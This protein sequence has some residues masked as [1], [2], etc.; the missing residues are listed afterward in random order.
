MRKVR[1]LW[2]G[3]LW[4]GNN[5]SRAASY[6]TVHSFW[7]FLEHLFC[8]SFCARLLKY[9]DDFDLKEQWVDI[10]KAKPGLHPPS[11]HP[12]RKER[13]KEEERKK[14]GRKRKEGRKEGSGNRLFQVKTLFWAESTVLLMSGGVW[15]ETLFRYRL[16]YDC[17]LRIYPMAWKYL[18][19]LW[20]GPTGLL[21]QPK[22]FLR[23]GVGVLPPGPFHWT[24][25]QH[26]EV[27]KTYALE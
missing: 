7:Q 27:L 24:A 2:S 15:V 9:K 1:T 12:L 19:A 16:S 4:G 5:G 8:V 6:V 25:H 23:K 21:S 10:H 14:E 20:I 26:L 22:T 3:G 17:S 18:S 11:I 13:R